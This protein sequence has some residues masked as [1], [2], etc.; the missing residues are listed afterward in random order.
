[1]LDFLPTQHFD[2]FAVQDGF[3]R[4][5]VRLHE[6]LRTRDKLYADVRLE[7]LGQVPG[8]SADDQTL[9]TW[10]YLLSKVN[11]DDA[12]AAHAQLTLQLRKYSADIHHDLSYEIHYA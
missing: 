2:R 10:E 6:Y 1:M 11:P 8:M 3:T 9:P 4:L 5:F 7:R 12:A